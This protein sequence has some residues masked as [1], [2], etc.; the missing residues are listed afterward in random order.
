MSSGP[1]KLEGFDLP[2]VS[3]TTSAPPP[4]SAF[5]V[6][7]SSLYGAA[8]GSAQRDSPFQ[9]YGGSGIGFSD[10]D[11]DF[12]L[13]LASLAQ[14]GQHTSGANNAFNPSSAGSFVGG[15]G[16][17]FLGHGGTFEQQFGFRPIDKQQ[18][19]QN[20]PM[21]SFPG[22]SQPPHVAPTSLPQY[23][24]S[25]TS[26]APLAPASIPAFTAD[27]SPHDSR[28][29][30]VMSPPPPVD[31]YGMHSPAPASQESPAEFG[32][33]S[34]VGD[35]FAQSQSSERRASSK[36][37]GRA[38]PP[39]TQ[40]RGRTAGRSKS[41]SRAASS[42]VGKAPAARVRSRSA[43]RNATGVAYQAMGT[44]GAAQQ[45]TAAASSSQVPSA[46]GIPPPTGSPTGSHPLAMSMPAYANG[47]G[48]AM[49]AAWYN[50]GSALGLG[51]QP[52][53]ELDASGWRPGG[54]QKGPNSA[55]SSAPTP[56]VAKKGKAQLDDVP[57]DGPAKQ[58]VW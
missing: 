52:T 5:S 2:G 38:S 54:E 13:T 21:S 8:F 32:S 9:S 34:S 42:S 6:D 22:A 45:A 17:H 3:G 11:L 56:G 39:E 30:S 37:R 44:G 7:P 48:A 50:S 1:I 24:S 28:S 12:D 51:G 55:P 46:I 26:S 35:A 36:S 20:L 10:L 27:P 18:P 4:S 16:A 40:E 47:G 15:G 19:Q 14:H 31:L 33:Y 23:F 49:P 53:P 58:S 25:A 41:A 29:P 43:R 57:E